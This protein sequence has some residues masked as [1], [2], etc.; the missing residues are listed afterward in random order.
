MGD[1]ADL[2]R[3]SSVAGT[4]ESNRNSQSQLI[5][6]TNGNASHATH[7]N[8]A[9]STNP[10]EISNKAEKLDKRRSSLGQGNQKRKTT[11]AHSDATPAPA[12]DSE[13]QSSEPILAKGER[14]LIAEDPTWNLSSVKRLTTLCI[15]VLVANFD[16]NPVLAPLPLKHRKV[17]LSL[18]PAEISLSVAAPIIPDASQEIISGV[19]SGSSQITQLS[20]TPTHPQVSAPSYWHRRA[21]ATFTPSECVPSHH[22]YSW[23]RLFFELYLQREIEGFV[24]PAGGGAAGDG[25]APPPGFSTPT[26]ISAA[27]AL[28]LIANIQKVANKGGTTGVP[29][30]PTSSSVPG[31][32]GRRGTTDGSQSSA[33]VVPVSGP[34]FS[35]Q[36]MA[37]LTGEPLAPNTLTTGEFADLLRISGPFIRTLRIEQLRPAPS[38][39]LPYLNPIPTT[40]GIMPD[41]GIPFADRS[42][43]GD[44]LDL[45]ELLGPGG[46]HGLRELE[47][48]FGMRDTAMNF[49]WKLFGM[50]QNDCIRLCRALEWQANQYQ[51]QIAK[52]PEVILSKSLPDHFTNCLVSLTI[53]R[54]AIDDDKCRLLCRAMAGG[55]IRKL[56]LSH[57]R[58]ASAGTRAI[59]HLLAFPPQPALQGFSAVYLPGIALTHLLLCNNRIDAVGAQ[60]LGRALWWNTSL[61]HLSLRLNDLGDAGG[62]E[63]VQ[64]LART[65]EMTTHPL[66][67]TA[68]GKPPGNSTVK[69]LDLASTGVGCDTAI[70]VGAALRRNVAAVLEKVDLSCNKFGATLQSESSTAAASTTPTASPSTI[71]L[72]D[73]PPLPSGDIKSRMA[74]AAPSRAE[75]VVSMS[76]LQG[77]EAMS[78]ED[79]AGKALLDGY[80]TRLD[81]RATDL[82]TEFQLALQAAVELN[83]SKLTP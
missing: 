42:L 30:S 8:E 12:T 70:A 21:L 5:A 36:L 53:T 40:P 55:P 48:Y 57:N 26:P 18:L 43:E 2:T 77:G 83:S 46:I 24:P 65:N 69:I 52:F 3:R 6:N 13:L 62:V 20:S 41:S 32:A 7:S 60:S 49:S 1:T 54:S 23:K 47:V 11:H 29:I 78:K 27:P 58:I 56:D 9:T 64:G 66:I 81:V 68:G 63:V 74:S 61:V 79:L 34:I 17:L 28:K 44:H 75:S 22:G 67:P 14:R 10:S 50:T 39:N 4:Q 16:Q 31:S 25:I 82:N 45:G 71:E 72:P 51:A 37:S 15:E 80:I 59:A 35:P 76:A 73:L 38:S 33:A 19:H